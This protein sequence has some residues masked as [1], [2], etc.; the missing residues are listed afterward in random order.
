MTIERKLNTEEFRTDLWESKFESKTEFNEVLSE[1]MDGTQVLEVPTNELSVVGINLG[2]LLVDDMRSDANISE[3]I[4]DYVIDDTASESGSNLAVK[5][6]GEGHLL[7]STAAACLI[8]RLGC[9]C[10]AFTKLPLNEKVEWLNTAAKYINNKKLYAIIR[11]DK[12][13]G[14]VSDRYNMLSQMELFDKTLRL[15]ADNFDYTQFQSGYISHDYTSVSAV[16]DDPELLDGYLGWMDDI[17]YDYVSGD[18]QIIVS[19]ATSDTTDSA[20][21][22]SV[23]LVDENVSILLGS[24]ISMPHYKSASIEAWEEKISGIAGHVAAL[25]SDL[26]HLGSI[27]LKYPDVVFASIGTEVGLG[28]KVLAAAMDDFHLL[29]SCLV[30]T[31]A[32]DVY[33]SLFKALYENRENMSKDMYIRVS[34]NLSRCVNAGF[35]WADYDTPVAL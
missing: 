34:E 15:L 25:M 10:P 28:K 21:N 2:G 29:S 4:P 3:D 19:V 5:I 33:Y 13:R 16:V 1:Y 26:V 30:K 20:V 24:P 23:R 31:T 8:G 27:E 35:S 18:A 22:L 11:G 14:L 9:Q 17:G 32:H 6:D 12:V 7:S